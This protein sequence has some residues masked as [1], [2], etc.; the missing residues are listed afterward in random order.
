MQHCVVLYYCPTDMLPM[1]H[2]IVLSYNVGNAAW[3]CI[4]LSYIYVGHVALY[5]LTFSHAALSCLVDMLAMQHSLDTIL[6]LL[7][8]EAAKT[9]EESEVSSRDIYCNLSL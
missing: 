1:Q 2:C 6:A 4:V 9:E 5:C 7:Q 3:Y 8:T